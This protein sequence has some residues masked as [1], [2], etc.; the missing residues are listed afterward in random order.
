MHFH[1]VIIF[2]FVDRT[3]CVTSRKSCRRGK[4]RINCYDISV[5]KY[6]YREICR[7]YLSFVK[8]Q[9]RVTS[10]VKGWFETRA[11]THVYTICTAII[12]HIQRNKAHRHDAQNYSFTYIRIYI[13]KCYVSAFQIEALRDARKNFVISIYFA[14]HWHPPVS[15]EIH[16]RSNLNFKPVKFCCWFRVSSRPEQ[17]A[18]G[19]GGRLGRVCTPPSNGGWQ[20]RR[21]VCIGCINWLGRCKL[22]I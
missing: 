22:E 1:K 3:I 4:R 20:R 2:S 15:R 5:T 19:R 10:R 13:C 16:L 8:I 11:S 12:V 6:T 21:R 18:R 14:H 17:K 9:A 7:R